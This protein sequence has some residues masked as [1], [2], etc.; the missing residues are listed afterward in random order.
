[1]FTI[2]SEFAALTASIGSQPATNT[3]VLAATDFLSGSR[4]LY[5][6]GVACFVFL[7][8]LGAGGRVVAAVWGGRKGDVVLWGLIGIVAAVIVGG[9]YAIY[10]SLDK[11]VDQTGITTG[12][13]G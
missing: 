13:F 7:I 12:Q 3:T 9:G 4:A 5:T 11:T 10:V 1:M 6:I 2:T 8:L